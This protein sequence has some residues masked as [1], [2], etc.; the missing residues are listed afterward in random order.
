MGSGMAENFVT[1]EL[2]DERGP[3]TLNASVIAS[4][5]PCTNK[6]GS[7]IICVGGA[8]HR[9]VESFS[10]L[11]CHLDPTQVVYA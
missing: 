1:V 3:V 11:A 5:R 7:L 8:V 9:V 4:V 2:S 6:Q 10:T